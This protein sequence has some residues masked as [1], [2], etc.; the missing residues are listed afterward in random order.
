MDQAELSQRVRWAKA[1]S[2]A[3]DPPANP[4][5]KAERSRRIDPEERGQDEVGEIGH[6][7]GKW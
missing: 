4:Q 5:M 7:P 2:S 6:R 1:G 3:N